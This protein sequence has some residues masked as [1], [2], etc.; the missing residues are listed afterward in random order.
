MGDQEALSLARAGARTLDLG[1]AAR[2]DKGAGCVMWC[3][4]QC[5]VLCNAARRLDCHD[6]HDETQSL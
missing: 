4:V 3:A 2:V 1:A 6:L 5:T